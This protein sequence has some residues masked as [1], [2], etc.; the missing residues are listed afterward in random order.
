MKKMNADKVYII[1]RSDDKIKAIFTDKN[2]A[3]AYARRLNFIPRDFFG[4][5]HVI[6]RSCLNP[7]LPSIPTS[8]YAKVELNLDNTVSV[9]DIRLK[10]ESI[11]FDEYLFGVTYDNPYGVAYGKEDLSNYQYLLMEYKIPIYR[12]DT[13]KSI[14]ERAYEALCDN[15]EKWKAWRLEKEHGEDKK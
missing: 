1:S 8:A 3:K 6:E 13:Q 11:F 4:R 12:N 10:K 2:K 5:Y 15:L 7:D 14:R 9:P